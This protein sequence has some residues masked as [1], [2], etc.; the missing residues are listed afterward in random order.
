MKIPS[1][2]ATRKQRVIALAVWMGL[3]LLV[4]AVGVG[5][6]QAISIALM[7]ATILGLGCYTVYRIMRAIS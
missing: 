1:P 7:L 6:P 5:I 4:A 3:L 2:L